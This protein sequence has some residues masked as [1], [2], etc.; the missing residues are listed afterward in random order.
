MQAHSEAPASEL[1]SNRVPSGD[2]AAGEPPTGDS[3]A[4]HAR[5]I[6]EQGYTIV[7]N[8]VDLDLIDALNEDLLRL[9]V[10]LGIVPADNLFEGSRTVRIYNLL[11]H[12]P[13]YEQIPVY[14]SILPICEGVLDSGLLVSPLSSNRHRPGGDPPDHPR[15]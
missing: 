1:G 10:D 15:R 7:E 6:A 2:H 8:A 4:A 9:E 3:V 11:V 14:P 5:Q 12:G 13:L